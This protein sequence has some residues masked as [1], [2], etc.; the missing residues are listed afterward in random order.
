MF[1]ELLVAGQGESMRNAVKGLL[2]IKERRLLMHQ[3]DIDELKLKQLEILQYVDQFCQ[4][5]DID[6]FL[7]GGTLLGAI[8]HKGYIPWDDDLDIGLLRKD[9]NKLLAIFNQKNRNTNYELIGSEIN[10]SYPYIYSKIIDKKT[11]LYEPDEKALK[12]SVNIDVFPYDDIPVNIKD[13]KVLYRK[14]SLYT[15]LSQ[16]QY[17]A[18]YPDSILKKLIIS[19]AQIILAFFPRGFFARKMICSIKQH[20]KNNQSGY[21]SDFTGTVSFKCDKQAFDSYVMKEFEG[22][23]FKVPERYD[24]LLTAIYGDYMKLPP[25][26]ERVS[27]HRFIAFS[28]ND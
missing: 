1:L 17:G 9:Y 3:I 21:V 15:T 24:L 19:V 18:I 22:K 25:V 23:M 5:N 6:Y 2:E 4:E 28:Y 7:D 8:R 20:C 14:R 11:I 16:L 12:L 26:E 10:N 13:L 27:H